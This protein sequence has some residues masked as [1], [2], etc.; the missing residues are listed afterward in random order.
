MDAAGNVLG[1]KTQVNTDISPVQTLN[2]RTG[3]GDKHQGTLGGDITNFENVSG[4]KV[5]KVVETHKREWMITKKIV[6]TQNGQKADWTPEAGKGAVRTDITYKIGDK[7]TPALSGLL[8]NSEFSAEGIMLRGD[9]DVS[10]TFD[11]VN[12][13]A[14]Y[15]ITAQNAST[16]SIDMSKTNDSKKNIPLN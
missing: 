6:L 15:S 12:G 9:I 2:G 8:K 4:G 14:N 1:S 11:I 3:V 5:C 16:G 13:K 10:A 7:T